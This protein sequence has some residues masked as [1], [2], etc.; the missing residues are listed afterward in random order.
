[1]SFRKDANEGQIDETFNQKFI[2]SK[3]DE[4]IKDFK[5]A[6]IIISPFGIVL[7]A[8]KRLTFNSD[9]SSSP[10]EEVLL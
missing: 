2:N 6:S 5:K 10:C 3:D 9:N 8:H 4:K 1:M 7:H